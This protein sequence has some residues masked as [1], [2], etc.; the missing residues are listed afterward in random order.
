MRLAGVETCGSVWTCPVC[1]AR[2]LAERAQEISTAVAEYGAHRSWMVTVTLRHGPHH[3][4]YVLRRVL[5]DAYARLKSGRWGQRLRAELGWRGD[6]S[7]LEVTHGENGW[8]PHLHAVW[9]AGSDAPDAEQLADAWRRAVE[10]T[11]AEHLR[12]AQAPASV[13]E[14]RLRAVVGA[15]YTD[16]PH[17][18]AEQVRDLVGVMPSADRGAVVTQCSDGAYLAKMGLEVSGGLQQTAAAGHRTAWQIAQHV[19]A[20]DVP[21]RRL[22]S[23]YSQALFGARQLVWSRAIRRELGLA[24]SRSDEL[25]ADVP[26]E[27]YAERMLIEFDGQEWR[28]LSRSPRWLPW[29]AEQYQ[30]GAL[31]P[32]V[33]LADVR[34][35]WHDRV[36]LR[37]RP[38]DT[39]IDGHRAAGAS[40]WRAAT[41]AGD[42]RYRTYTAE[43][44]RLA[45]EEL[46][47]H[48]AIDLRVV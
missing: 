25:V 13:T 34:A 20:G 40:V 21:S 8:H 24:P 23:D 30:S 39:D 12:V 18:Y 1:A 28:E 2:I 42:R 33:E 22:W 10:T 5:R 3:D 48:L 4:L 17:V 36:P 27:P 16:D 35:A 47:H 46:A 6:V 37:V 29:L 14:Q 15:R 31:D 7:A 32:G 9:F 41:V 19:A 26:A 38:P 45:R 11:V 43:D 44:R